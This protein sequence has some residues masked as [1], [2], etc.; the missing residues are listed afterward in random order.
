MI[1]QSAPI[2]LQCSV[3]FIQI[4]HVCM[5]GPW[6]VAALLKALFLVVPSFISLLHANVGPPFLIP[7]LAQCLVSFLSSFLFFLVHSCSLSHFPFPIYPL[8]SFVP[9]LTR[10]GPLDPYSL[11]P[12]VS[13]LSLAR[14]LSYSYLPALYPTSNHL[15]HH[16][17]PSSFVP[18]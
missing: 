14:S 18:S 8:F 9:R 4:W 11:S 10:Y 13:S 1:L 2:Y 17:L 6:F 5:D 16:S 3:H 7:L 15:L 12:S